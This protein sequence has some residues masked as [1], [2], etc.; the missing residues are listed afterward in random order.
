VVLNTVPSRQGQQDDLYPDTKAIQKS[1]GVT[2]TCSLEQTVDKT[3]RWY[4][5][6]S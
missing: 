3:W 1:L 6:A 4:S 2:Q 5:A